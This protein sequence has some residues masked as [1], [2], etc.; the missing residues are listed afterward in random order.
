MGGNELKEVDASLVGREDDDDIFRDLLEVDGCESSWQDGDGRAEAVKKVE[1]KEALA[2]VVVEQ[3][4][5]EDVNPSMAKGNVSSG[6]W[7]FLWG[8]TAVI[9]VLPSVREK[10]SSP[11]RVVV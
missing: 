8:P 9:S 4:I 11:A 2:P 7:K 5:Q 3:Q 10:P 1:E 6:F